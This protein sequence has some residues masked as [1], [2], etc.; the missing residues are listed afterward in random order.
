M[1]LLPRMYVPRM[2]F[3]A[4]WGALMLV[5]AGA[6]AG[7]DPFAGSYPRAVS[8][9]AQ[10]LQIHMDHADEA[11]S[12]RD[13]RRRAEIGQRELLEEWELLVGLDEDL[14]TEELGAARDELSAYIERRFVEWSVARFFEANRPADLSSLLDEVAAANLQLLY[15]T[16]GNGMVQYDSAGAPLMQRTDGLARDHDEW[17]MRVAE[18]VDREV[19]AWN[20]QYDSR[21]ISMRAGIGADSSGHG[22]DPVE[23]AFEVAD[24][25]ITRQLRRELEAVMRLEQQRFVARRTRDRWSLRRDSES[26]TAEEITA[27]LLSQT[28]YELEESMAT[29][30]ET[31]RDGISRESIDQDDASEIEPEQAVW[32]ER[33]REQFDAGMRR[34]DRAEQRLLTERVEWEREAGV[35][36]EHGEQVWAQAYRQLRE[37]RA[38]WRNEF[39]T[40]I[41]RGRRRWAD[42][43]ESLEATIAESQ[44]EL[45]HA[46]AQ[47]RASAQSRMDNLVEMYL[48]ARDTMR[49]TLS[50]VEHWFGRLEHTD[51]V[52]EDITDSTTVE[53]LLQGELEGTFAQV[54]ASRLEKAAQ[55]VADAE[56][57]IENWQPEKR[58][59]WQRGSAEV[60]VPEELT[61]A[62][63]E[64]HAERSRIEH[65]VD[66]ASWV[67]SEHMSLNAFRNEI[68]YDGHAVTGIETPFLE[69][70]YAQWAHRTQAGPLPAMNLVDETLGNLPNRRVP[71][72][73]IFWMDTWDRY[74][75]QAEQAMH[76]LMTTYGVVL[77]DDPAAPGEKDFDFDEILAR[78]GA[79]SLY[80]DDYQVE[81]LRSR[82]TE[83]YWEHQL[84]IARSVYEYAAD[85][86]SDRATEAETDAE[87]R[88]ALSAFESAQ[89]AY[90]QSGNALARAGA[91]LAS[92]REVLDELV[93][94][95]ET[96]QEQLVQ[97]RDEYREVMDLHLGE[98]HDFYEQQIAGY[99][100]ELAGIWGMDSEVERGEQE[101]LREY[102][103]ARA[104][105][106]M[107][108]EYG[109]AW[110]R[111]D[112]LV[113]ELNGTDS[114]SGVGVP[115]VH[116]RA[117]DA[118]AWEF[119]GN[120]DTF[121]RSLHSRDADTHN[122][123]DPNDASERDNVPGYLGLEPSVYDTN[124]APQNEAA[125]LT[126][127]HQRYTDAL[128]EH[129][130]EAE[131]ARA[132]IEA[133]AG[134]HVAFAGEAR[135]ELE[136]RLLLLT[137][138]SP[139]TWIR[140]AGLEDELGAQNVFGEDGLELEAGEGLSRVGS[141]LEGA[142]RSAEIEWL[143]RRVQR[144]RDAIGVL[145]DW[146]EG[147]DEP[148]SVGASPHAADTAIHDSETD[149][150]ARTLALAWWQQKDSI[151]SSGIASLERADEALLEM[152][153][154]LNRAN[155]SDGRDMESGPLLRDVIT[156]YDYASRFIGGQSLFV[157]SGED[158][159][160]SIAEYD[161]N[162]LSRVRAAR[163]ALERHGEHAHGLATLRFE[164]SLSQLVG[165]LDSH[166][167]LA[168][169]PQRTHTDTVQ[170]R[171]PSEI[172]TRLN[173]LTLPE[174]AEWRLSVTEEIQPP[175]SGLDGA[176]GEELARWL[177]EVEN[178]TFAGRAGDAQEQDYRDR[179]NEAE[180]A[181]QN[182]EELTE[183]HSDTEAVLYNSRLSESTKLAA[184]LEWWDTAGQSADEQE[185]IADVFIDLL[186]SAIAPELQAHISADDR[187]EPRSFVETRVDE[188]LNTLA[189]SHVPSGYRSRMVEETI[190]R[191]ERASL[192]AS[193]TSEIE[194]ETLSASER[195]AVTLGQWEAVPPQDLIEPFASLDS[196]ELFHLEEFSRWADLSPDSLLPDSSLAR[197]WLTDRFGS[198]ESDEDWDEALTAEFELASELAYSLTRDYSSYASSNDTTSESG[199]DE[200]A[201]A[202]D[203]AAYTVGN[204]VGDLLGVGV[205]ARLVKE[206]TDFAPEVAEPYVRA[207]SLGLA[208]SLKNHEA[209][210]NASGARTGEDDSLQQ[211][212]ETITGVE[213]LA[214]RSDRF[215]ERAAERAPGYIYQENEL[216]AGYRAILD[217]R[218]GTAS[219]DIDHEGLAVSRE[220]QELA[221]GYASWLDGTPGEFAKEVSEDLYQAL[222][223]SASIGGY[224]QMNGYV[225][226]A[227]QVYNAAHVLEFERSSEAARAESAVS[228]LQAQM[229]TQ[230][231]RLTHDLHTA[232]HLKRYYHTLASA[233]RRNE[234]EA[235]NARFYLDDE[236]LPEGGDREWTI[237]TSDLD[238]PR[239]MGE[240]VYS[241]A[242]YPASDDWVGQER[243]DRLNHLARA[244]DRVEFLISDARHVH[245]TARSRTWQREGAGGEFPMLYAGDEGISPLEH[246]ESVL[247]EF[248]SLPKL[249][250]AVRRRLRESREALADIRAR[251]I[252]L[253]QEIVTIGDG[254]RS[255]RESGDAEMSASLEPVEADIE[256]S[257]TR[258]ATLDSQLSSALERFE[259][260]NEDYLDLSDRVS[261]NRETVELARLRLRRAEAI[262]EFAST[263]YIGSDVESASG[264]GV[265]DSLDP[266]DPGEVDPAAVE[267]AAVDPAGRLESAL[268]RRNQARAARIAL[269]S[270]PNNGRG[271]L[272][273]LDTDAYPEL[274]AYRETFQEYRTRY[275]DMLTVQA[276]EALLGEAVIR[277]KEI[278]DE[279]FAEA[280]GILEQVLLPVSTE[281]D[282]EW[283]EFVAFGHE[284]EGQAEGVSDAHGEG[285]GHGE[286]DYAQFSLSIHG[287]DVDEIEAYFRAEFDN[288]RES[289][290]ERRSDFERDRH[291]WMHEVNTLIRERG[292]NIL[293]EWGL[294]R[295][296]RDLSLLEALD[297]HLAGEPPEDEL[298]AKYNSR[299][300]RTDQDSESTSLLPGAPGF[301]EFRHQQTAPWRKAGVRVRERLGI[302]AGVTL[303]E[304]AGELSGLS[305]LMSARVRRPDEMFGNAIDEFL[306]GSLVRGSIEYDKYIRSESRKAYHSVMGDAE[307]RD[308]FEFYSGLSFLGATAS[309]EP[310]AGVFDETGE[311]QTAEYVID[312]LGALRRRN[313][314]RAVTSTVLGSQFTAM[315]LA[316]L[317]WP[318]AYAMFAVAAGH[319]SAA[320]VSAYNARR[321]G[322]W[323]GEVAE[324]SDRVRESASRGR[325]SLIESAAAYVDSFSLLQ[326]ERERL[327]VLRG[328]EGDRER[329]MEPEELERSM[330]VAA[331]VLNIDLDEY[332][333]TQRPATEGDALSGLFQRYSGALNGESMHTSNDYIVA[334]N[335][336]LDTRV[337]QA[338]GALAGDVSRL[339]EDQDR[340]R[341][342]YRALADAVLNRETTDTESDTDQEELQ[343]LLD[344][345]F[346]EGSLLQREYQRALLAVHRESHARYD[347]L[348]HER[349]SNFDRQETVRIKQGLLSM[350]DGR[351]ERY[352]EMKHDEFNTYRMDLANRRDE[353]ERTVGAISERADR[354]WSY[355]E[356]LL[357]TRRSD[358]INDLNANFEHGAE[359]WNTRY[360]SLRERRAEWV[361]SSA[362]KAE[363][364]DSRSALESVGSSSDAAIARVEAMHIPRLR[365]GA[366]Q[367]MHVDTLVTEVLD[368][369]DFASL[370]D[371]TITMNRSI[372][373]G[374]PNI[375]TTLGANRFTDTDIL[376]R[377][378]ASR[379][380][381]REAISRGLSL[382]SAEQAREQF[383]EIAAELE[384]EVDAANT[385]VADSSERTF[386]DAGWRVNGSRFTRDTVIG[387]TLTSGLVRE[388]HRV[389]QIR[390][391]DDYDF[392]LDTDLSVDTLSR[393]SSRGIS[394]QLDAAVNELQ[395]E[396]EEVFGD[397]NATATVVAEA[398]EDRKTIDLERGWF[399]SKF[400]IGE[401]EMTVERQAYAVLQ[402]GKFGAY[403][404]YAPQ[405]TP[406]ID[407]DKSWRDNVLFAGMGQMHRL[408]GEYSFYEAM[409]EKGYAE[410]NAGL[411]NTPIWSGDYAPTIRTV[412]DTGARVA[413]T[414]ATGGLASA[415]ITLGNSVLWDA[416]DMVSGTG[417]AEETLLG[418]A[419]S[420]VLSAVGA[421]SAMLGDGV[422]H[423]VGS[424]VN[425]VTVGTGVEQVTQAVLSHSGGAAVNAVHLGDSGDLSFSTDAFLEGSL[426]RQ[427]LAGYAGSALGGALR[428]GI[429]DSANVDLLGFDIGDDLAALDLGVDRIAELS[430][431]VVDQVT[432]YGLGGQAR[433]NLLNLEDIGRG[434][435]MIGIESQLLRDGA[436]SYR[437]HGLL[438]IGLGK[439]ERVGSY[440]TL[441][442][443]GVN[444]SASQLRGAGGQAG[445]FR[446]A[447]LVQEDIRASAK[448]R[449][450]MFDQSEVI[451]RGVLNFE[452]NSELAVSLRADLEKTRSGL[453]KVNLLEQAQL[454]GEQKGA[455]G[456]RYAGD[457]PVSDHHLDRQLRLARE[458]GDL[459]RETFLAHASRFDVQ[460]G[461]DWGLRLYFGGHTSADYLMATGL[462]TAGRESRGSESFEMRTALF[463]DFLEEELSTADRLLGGEVFSGDGYIRETIARNR[464]ESIEPVVHTIADSH[465]SLEDVALQLADLQVSLHGESGE[466][467]RA[468]VP[469]AFLRQEIAEMNLDVLHTRTGRLPQVITDLLNTGAFDDYTAPSALDSGVPSVQT[470]EN[471]SGEHF[472][473]PVA[474]SED[475]GVRLTSDYALRAR[476]HENT[477]G[478]HRFSLLGQH[479]ALDFSV[480]GDS[481]GRLFA[482]EKGNVSLQWDE[483][484]VHGLAVI[485][486]T[487]SQEQHIYSHSS[488][489]TLY[490]VGKAMLAAGGDAVE[491]GTVIGRSKY[492]TSTGFGPAH[493]DFA[494]RRNVP[495][496]DSVFRSGSPV[497]PMNEHFSGLQ[498]AKRN[499]D[500]G[501][502]VEV[503][504]RNY[505]DTGERN[506]AL[507]DELD[508]R[509]N[510]GLP[511]PHESVVRAAQSLE[512]RVPFELQQYYEDLFESPG[513]QIW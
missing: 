229:E 503:A 139:E 403:V 67:I 150:F 22:I 214:G 109:R 419:R 226:G 313:R 280:N 510:R 346:G 411:H 197:Q 502:Y 250:S 452:R 252:H 399:A 65:S 376:R 475:E 293:R 66:F 290:D 195:N 211:W 24:A 41:A 456:F 415:A 215:G 441:G 431:G 472:F 357:S 79:D 181:E 99:F 45:E 455:H 12:A 18:A 258:L 166:G 276:L 234:S 172:A 308:L 160:R 23:E 454:R 353:W 154:A 437:R 78:G 227:G 32:S 56:A 348:A 484:N 213:G 179:A 76:D 138:D 482:H 295:Y 127:L 343:G 69:D 449:D 164:E 184:A 16:D 190:A 262:L 477:S 305:E 294:A 238:R 303:D 300:L 202:G 378:H 467:G 407:F 104:E 185:A 316:M 62:L 19:A 47:R 204:R 312:G 443:G 471:S 447:G 68:K 134:R 282:R 379:A 473:A 128:G 335:A 326:R 372:S 422:G 321:A 462:A 342:K 299:Y 291:D 337:V 175:A 106:D 205:A 180:L 338:R 349:L 103:G 486:E 319:F 260:S 216:A 387:D 87:Y 245:E 51:A 428:G 401:G 301:D 74:Q 330:V 275:E 436:G 147:G 57:S 500:E 497:D 268:H 434:L 119:S 30:E 31:L 355:S 95:V 158:L 135:E 9:E 183:L 256:A 281:P 339:R 509:I 72:Q 310:A 228:V 221:A 278:V 483:T 244:S 36:L 487:D 277:Q 113:G 283:V 53:R 375:I 266:V 499:I 120:A 254:L 101:R 393:M 366:A 274:H 121:T 48:S 463:H 371:R 504:N 13:W 251:A 122:L 187:E 242:T 493:L 201:P 247:Q 495:E 464:M 144:E 390:P 85:E 289:D 126:A 102:R 322:D 508:R 369:S 506:R 178:L 479:N 345:A 200:S 416:A 149:P 318:P 6:Y 116:Q 424:G 450:W 381:D 501:Q 17:E 206:L 209:G 263:G 77:A 146:L 388:R 8:L 323:R 302:S 148:R 196:R 344:R 405:L 131:L 110:E 141:A 328:A 43:H 414:L 203:K 82:A 451:D 91:D 385:A 354:Q 73:L 398:G 481:A 257:E 440:V 391:F 259:R 324:K 167:L 49:T 413:A 60:S 492:G 465:E 476:W 485:M 25:R 55:N 42:E 435:S 306:D 363:E 235:Y 425:S 155:T 272:A 404:G 239:D 382:V 392:G 173:G 309:Q 83:Q 176:L 453:S 191:W 341:R 236:Y 361:R 35:T 71:G 220:V 255:A 89:N 231:P 161:R 491:A 362:A 224:T 125:R 402:P 333:G 246:A 186:A 336:E 86:S 165:V 327:A 189:F 59:P 34:W 136:A 358:W 223:V 117:E 352:L 88:E 507:I 44:R 156:Q 96:E 193:K 63:D 33:F 297:T 230:G 384:K 356:R 222:Q 488:P 188:R 298:R 389:K 288:P 458:Q 4:I 347:T 100:E 26:S 159:S 253:Q 273:E 80:M 50:A 296:Y 58:F 261:E 340:A 163:K 307:S 365:A 2:C 377:V 151:A 332:L 480:R 489:E 460:E 394:A 84:E 27:R 264:S 461:A 383:A 70:L 445:N 490:D 112:Q 157:T 111:I 81:V 334:L 433:A 237:V 38:E 426:G 367:N 311:A 513:E 97:A 5:G 37:R 133:I 265:A 162:R 374:R 98:N 142:E 92:N 418:A 279:R 219:V 512:Q 470:W 429:Q 118:G 351:Y 1:Y 241:F 232:S 457:R 359:R 192:R 269:E 208:E 287:N 39:N 90:E 442:D 284:H 28:E 400:D 170:F 194:W 115:A 446:R 267:P 14:D 315:G 314:S 129:P 373:R 292:S 243:T 395:K 108:L 168:V 439:H 505:P 182:L 494:V 420:G 40:V 21:L 285:A 410:L 397:R 145:R 132:A 93:L 177:E 317:P 171:A 153:S 61:N 448:R 29:L 210:S 105:Y 107:E 444:M 331:R 169:A 10:A 329:P 423:A 496:G 432:R 225:H 3:R 174:V 409:Q 286:G 412:A 46:I 64:A 304:Y 240:V 421:G 396:L 364:T 15:E 271:E 368:G 466:S 386:R 198:S 114:G 360:L 124:G 218:S 143:T 7:D 20:K 140:E 249:D 75:Y 438:E 130:V 468:A 498:T 350:F 320:G 54:K 511:R 478:G 212:F 406:N 233:V 427:A 152:Q 207:M 408:M 417:S 270:L 430:G 94:A 217:G 370:L 325:N 137:A 469:D 248:G 52:A 199:T 459:A 123:A 474:D 380:A 11:A